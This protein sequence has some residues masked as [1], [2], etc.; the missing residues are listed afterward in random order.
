MTGK[1]SINVNSVLPLSARAAR[2]AARGGLAV[3]VHEFPEG[4]S[5]KPE[6]CRDAGDMPDAL[7]CIMPQA[8]ETRTAFSSSFPRPSVQTLI[9]NEN[10]T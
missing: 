9:S 7:D 5:E 8:L 10:P 2:I 6:E 3:S 4:K 1:K